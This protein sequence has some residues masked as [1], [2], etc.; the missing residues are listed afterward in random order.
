MAPPPQV[1]RTTRA[2]RLRQDH[3]LR[4]RHNIPNRDLLLKAV[5]SRRVL[6]AR[7]NET[8]MLQS[9]NDKELYTKYYQ[10]AKGSLSAYN[11]I[12]IHGIPET[13]A[14]DGEE[15]VLPGVKGKEQVLDF[16]DPNPTRGPLLHPQG[17]T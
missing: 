2:T 6:R 4:T 17:V 15:L 3:Q 1:I 7:E 12:T 10:E 14:Q 13:Q 11:M 9:S 5:V 8:A 16:D